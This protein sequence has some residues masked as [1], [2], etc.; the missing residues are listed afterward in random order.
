MLFIMSQIV[1]VV[2]LS[3]GTI[4]WCPPV[5]KTGG[6]GG[7]GGGGCA[8]LAPPLPAPMHGFALPSRVISSELKVPYH[9]RDSK[10]RDM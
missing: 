5:Q 6:G 9:G 3:A 10:G 4:S 8:L 1:H 2:L 7:G